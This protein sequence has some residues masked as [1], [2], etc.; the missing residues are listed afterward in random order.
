LII[1]TQEYHQPKLPLLFYRCGHKPIKPE[2]GALFRLIQ[3]EK[4]PF[5]HSGIQSL[6]PATFHFAKT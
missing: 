1:K 6:L 5:Y 2:V 4:L 3:N